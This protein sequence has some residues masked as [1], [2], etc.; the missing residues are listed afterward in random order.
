MSNRQVLKTYKQLLRATQ[1]YPSS[2]RAQVTEAIR[3]EFRENIHLEGEARTRALWLAEM[4]LKRLQA[5]LPT[6]KRM[7]SGHTDFDVKL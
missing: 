5:W 7:R 6:A 3:A 2:K 1:Q 4:E